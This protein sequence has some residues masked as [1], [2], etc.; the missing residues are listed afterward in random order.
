VT[1]TSIAAPPTQAEWT[2]MVY[3]NGKNNLEPYALKNFHDMAEVGSTP[4]VNIVVEMGRPKST[5]YSPEDGDW[6]GVKRFLVR[7]GDAPTPDMALMDLEKVGE[8]TDMGSADTFRRFIQWTQKEYPAKRYMV[9]V[10]NHGQGWRYQLA[11]S[12]EA[13]IHAAAGR[14]AAASAVAKIEDVPAVGGFRSISHDEDS[15][16]ILY[17]F[18]VQ[19]AF[20]D[21]F[22]TDRKLDLL[23]FDACL[24]GMLE[25]AYAFRNNVSTMVASE[26]LEPGDGWHYAPWL[27]TL[28]QNPS[29]SG[30]ELGIAVV[31]A[32]QARYGNRGI[33][34]LSVVRLANLPSVASDISAFA[35]A[36]AKA[37]KAETDALLAARTKLRPYGSAYNL[38]TSV[39][40]SAL[41]AQY[42]KITRDTPLRLRSAALRTK[43]NAQVAK[44]YASTRSANP[45]QDWMPY[46]SRGVAIYFP[47]SKKDFESDKE[48][49]GYLKTNMIKPVEFV[50]KERWADLLYKILGM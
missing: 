5:R 6:T 29:M 27:V 44:N 19:Q 47:A 21:Q 31:D 22:P 46:G 2:V 1:V 24:M 3:M 37:G 28:T 43:I 8:P 11:K 50:Q 35:D 49:Q 26:E 40:L 32:Y 42:E 4:E 38:K 41:L 20:L 14:I 13:R 30:E 48:H 23:G 39:D 45:N 12:S 33:E 34:T 16:N 18:D 7:K 10:W 15:N 25:T 17:N 36:I 9:V